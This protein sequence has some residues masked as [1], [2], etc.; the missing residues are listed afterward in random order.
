MAEAPAAGIDHDDNLVRGQ[1]E[2]GS[3]FFIKD[4][5]YHGDL[6]EVVA[7]PQGGELVHPGLGLLAAGRKISPG[8][9]APLFDSF[10]VFFGGQAQLDQVGHALFRNFLEVAVQFIPALGANA[11]GDELFDGHQELL[12]IPGAQVPPA[13]AG[14]KEPDT[15]VDIH[16]HGPGRDHPFGIADGQDPADGKAITGMDVGHAENIFINPGQSGG[17]GQ[18]L[19]GFFL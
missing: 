10:Q 17:I 13:E 9:A 3:S 1:V 15:A 12:D 2:V 14:G 8:Q 19:D 16:A 5:V 6:Y 4:L 11:G 18:L 7:S